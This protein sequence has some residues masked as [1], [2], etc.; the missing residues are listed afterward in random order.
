MP[1]HIDA[2][3]IEI[4]NNSFNNQLLTDFKYFPFFLSINKFILC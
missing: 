2:Y 4:K 3:E 1:V